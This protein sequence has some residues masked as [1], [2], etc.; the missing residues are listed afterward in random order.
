LKELFVIG[1]LFVNENPSAA[2]Q[3]TICAK[4]IQIFTSSSDW[5]SSLFT[6]WL[7][8]WV[9]M[10]SMKVWEHGESSIKQLIPCGWWLSKED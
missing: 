10:I 9:Q 5:I 6:A 7:Q 4:K 8:K 1:D 2:Y 3:V